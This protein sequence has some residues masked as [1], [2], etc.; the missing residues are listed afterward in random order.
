MNRVGIFEQ[1]QVSG[2]VSFKP[3]SSPYEI[4]VR[5]S[6]LKFQAEAGTDPRNFDYISALKNTAPSKASEKNFGFGSIPSQ[7]LVGAFGFFND[8]IE[9]TVSTVD[10]GSLLKNGQ[11]VLLAGREG[12]LKHKAGRWQISWAEL[13]VRSRMDYPVGLEFK[14]G[15]LHKIS[16]NT[17]SDCGDHKVQLE[18]SDRPIAFSN[19]EFFEREGAPM[20][21]IDVCE[22]WGDWED[23]TFSA[24]FGSNTSINTKCLKRIE[25][26]RNGNF[27]RI[28]FSCPKEGFTFLQGEITLS[29][30]TVEHDRESHLDFYADGSIKSFTL[31]GTK[32]AYI[33]GKKYRPG[34]AVNLDPKGNPI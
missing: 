14:K 12:L 25:F 13:S 20:S 27:S 22:D 30:Q 6:V 32:N 9:A 34:N 7:A 11:L 17:R 29:G 18:K 24:K 8:E 3:D 10:G 21:S 23:R 2:I 19:I 28:S 26:Y 33:G 16:Q 5:D 31:G 1:L 4:K 15:W